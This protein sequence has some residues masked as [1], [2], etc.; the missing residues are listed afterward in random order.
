M[1]SPASRYVET[2]SNE[3]LKLARA[4]SPVE[5]IGQL[6]ENACA[7]YDKFN[8][9]IFEVT[10]LGGQ[11]HSINNPLRPVNSVEE[12]T[13]VAILKSTALKTRDNG[14]GFLHKSVR[15]MLRSGYRQAHVSKKLFGKCHFQMLFLRCLQKKQMLAFSKL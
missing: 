3:R 14:R 4:Y 8:A 12:V 6:V 5:C 7:V 9:T 1:A 11:F 15:I 13:D 2:D 10:V